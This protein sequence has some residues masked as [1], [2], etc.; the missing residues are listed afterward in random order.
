MAI[1]YNT[2][3]AYKVSGEESLGNFVIPLGSGQKARSFPWFWFWQF[4]WF[5]LS[6]AWL[7][8]E[9]KNAINT[10]SCNLHVSWPFFV[11]RVELKQ[12]FIYCT[13]PDSNFTKLSEIHDGTW[14]KCSSISVSTEIEWHLCKLGQKYLNVV[15]SYVNIFYSQDSYTLMNHDTTVV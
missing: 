11:Q 14:H 9:T 12:H 15:F 10:K 13:R 1:L 2:K 7:C 3:T 8:L 5:I 4:P 6:W